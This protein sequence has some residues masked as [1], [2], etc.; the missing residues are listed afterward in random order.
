MSYHTSGSMSRSYGGGGYG[1]IKISLQNFGTFK[2]GDGVRYTTIDEDTSQP[3]DHGFVD[4]YKINGELFL[5]D[6]QYTIDGQNPPPFRSGDTII[7][8]TSLQTTIASVENI[9]LNEFNPIVEINLDSPI[10]FPPRFVYKFGSLAGE[11]YYGAYHKHQD[12][13]LMIGGGEINVIHDM[14]PEEI[15]VLREEFDY[16]AED[17]I[18]SAT[19]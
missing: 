15:I 1:T 19:F 13:T 7:V 11:P 18:T 16:G 12:G 10:V 2:S 6:P 8:D 9:S 17:T 5:I 14:I 3:L 4:V